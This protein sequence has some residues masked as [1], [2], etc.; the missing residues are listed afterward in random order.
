[1]L[2]HCFIL[3]HSNFVKWNP[4]H[5]MYSFVCP[6]VPFYCYI[7]VLFES[8]EVASLISVF[9]TVLIACLAGRSDGCNFIGRIL[10]QTFRYKLCWNQLYFTSQLMRQ[11]FGFCA[12]CILPI[13]QHKILDLQKGSCI[14]WLPWTT[15]SVVTQAIHRHIF[16]RPFVSQ[17][18]SLFF[19]LLTKVQRRLVDLNGGIVAW[20]M[21]EDNDWCRLLNTLYYFFSLCCIFC[22]YV[23]LVNIVALAVLN[24]VWW[25][26]SKTTFWE[27]L[28]KLRRKLLVSHFVTQKSRWS[29]GNNFRL[30]YLCSS[31]IHN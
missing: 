6:F 21:H 9:A 29:L 27:L 12:S 15:V 14:L 10:E 16:L 20:K 11:T 25:E 8:S 22:V 7:V 28:G 24:L 4:S 19:S 18:L 23:E 30:H 31:L 5:E 2:T 13:T 1:M 3:P 17:G 26:N